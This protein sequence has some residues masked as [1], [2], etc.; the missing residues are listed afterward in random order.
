M[1]D[2]EVAR[3]I[4]GYLQQ[5]KLIFVPPP[6]EVKWHIE[7]VKTKCK[8]VQQRDDLPIP[9]QVFAKAELT[10][11]D[12][13]ALL[14][15]IAPSPVADTMATEV[16]EDID[17]LVRKSPG[18]LADIKRLGESGWQIENG[19]PHGGSYTNRYNK[20]ITLDGDLR[21]R[22]SAYV[23]V[24]SHEVGHAAYSYDED[25]SSKAAYVKGKLEDEA[26]ATMSNIRAQREILANHGPNIGVAGANSA[27]Y[28]AA[29]DKY[30]QDGNA[31]AC[32]AAIGT[33]F[34]DEVTSN[35]GQRYADYYG[36]WYD[37]TSA[38][39]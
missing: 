14:N 25:V 26:A 32:R 12:L 33:A 3:A 7:E 19:K 39:R 37:K 38:F 30:L 1:S 10:R 36:S 2:H 6:L 18:L 24:L 17:R 35:T 23:Q 21:S 20:V 16:G 31:A 5:G 34:G 28:N 27:A 15:P 13:P 8:R 9:N 4:F 22:P 29:Y 11:T